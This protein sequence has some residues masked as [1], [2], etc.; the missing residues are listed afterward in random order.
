MCAENNL[1][2]TYVFT[3][4]FSFK[5]SAYASGFPVLDWICLWLDE[6]CR[7]SLVGKWLRRF[8]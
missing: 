2:S 4:G 3:W 5:E 7:C 1:F 8:Y 6:P